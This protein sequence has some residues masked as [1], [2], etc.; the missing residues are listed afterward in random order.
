VEHS[1]PRIAPSTP[2][3]FS[4]ANFLLFTT[5]IASDP[6]LGSLRGKGFFVSKLA[7]EL[8]GASLSKQNTILHSFAGLIASEGLS[9][10]W[11]SGLWNGT[12]GQILSH[13]GSAT[14]VVLADGVDLGGFV[15]PVIARNGR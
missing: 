15:P 7:Y 1:D 4:A 14:N 10:A 11:M 2:R 3:Q 9:R 5:P 8:R 13:W 6:K 12:Y